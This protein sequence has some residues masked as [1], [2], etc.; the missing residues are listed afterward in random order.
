MANNAPNGQ[1]LSALPSWFLP[2]AVD[3]EPALLRPLGSSPHN[4]SAQGRDAE[5]R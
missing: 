5:T 4:R 1:E 3:Q 2:V